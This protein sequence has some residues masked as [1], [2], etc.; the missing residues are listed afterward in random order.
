M[1][2][3]IVIPYRVSRLQRY[4]VTVRGYVTGAYT[5]KENNAYLLLEFNGEMVLQ[6]AEADT[7]CVQYPLTFAS[8]TTIRMLQ[9]SFIALSLELS[10]NGVC[11]AI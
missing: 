6:M 8:K 7:V 4:G 9:P 11:D 5:P 10:C 1:K 2:V 3:Q